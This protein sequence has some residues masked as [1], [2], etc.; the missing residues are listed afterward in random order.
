MFNSPRS[1]RRRRRE[2]LAKL[3]PQRLKVLFEQFGFTF[4]RIFQQ[5]RTFV[6][7]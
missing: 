2:Q 5:A 3:E 7:E 4:E 6:L 1:A